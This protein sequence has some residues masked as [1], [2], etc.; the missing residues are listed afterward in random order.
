[1]VMVA[2][3]RPQDI[4]K[5]SKQAQRWDTI[6]VAGLIILIACWILGA[7]V[8]SHLNPVCNREGMVCTKAT[9]SE[10]DSYESAPD[11]CDGHFCRR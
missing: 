5:D 9:D 3:V 6:I 11:Y 8:Y 4:K 7:I 1:M 2:I 10:L